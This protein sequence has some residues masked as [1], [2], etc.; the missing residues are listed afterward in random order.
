MDGHAHR[1]VGVPEQL[2]GRQDAARAATDD[3]N[4]VNRHGVSLENNFF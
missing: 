3:G 1:A 4:L 2:E